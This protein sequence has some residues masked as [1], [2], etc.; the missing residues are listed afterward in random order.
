LPDPLHATL[1]RDHEDIARECLALPFVVGL[2]NGSLKASVFRRYVEQD[3]FFLRAFFS[4]YALAAVKIE[5]VD[6]VRRL[7]KLMGGVLEELELH[8]KYATELDIDLDE[9]QPNPTTSVYTDFLLRTAWTGSTSE[10]IAAMTPCM[11]LYAWLGQQLAS[12][13]HTPGPYRDWV[14]T[15]A[16]DEFAGLATNLEHLLDELAQDTPQ[17]RFN[18]K[19]ALRCELDFFEVQLLDRS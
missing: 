14:E 5:P 11:R 9:V 10:I 19:Y 1:W 7:H 6:L 12:P 3:A 18:Y 2:G 8:R 16:S 15:Y 17:I 4:A 13:G